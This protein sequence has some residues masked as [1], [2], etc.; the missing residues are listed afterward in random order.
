MTNNQTFLRQL[1][2]YVVTPIAL[3]LIFIASCF[4]LVQKSQTHFFEQQLFDFIE[5]SISKSHAQ[6]ND[7]RA[8]VIEQ[9]LELGPVQHLSLYNTQTA[10]IDHFGLPM[11]PPSSAQLHN[12]QPHWHSRNIAYKAFGLDSN[13]WLIAGISNHDLVIN[14]YKSIFFIVLVSIMVLG[15]VA[16]FTTRLHQSITDPLQ[17]IILQTRKLLTYEVKDLIS[18]KNPNIFQDL[19]N[20]INEIVKFQSAIHEEM[21]TFGE[22]STRELRETL[23]TVEIQNIELDIARKN[24]LQASKAKSEFLAN[25]SHELR[26]P[27][28]VILGFS[29]LLLKT[30]LSNQQRDYLATIEQSS[31]GLLTVINDIL[32]FS[33]LETGQL[34]LE[35]K[36][37]SLREI[38]EEI[39]AIYAPSAHEK[40]LRLLSMIHRNIPINLLGDPHRIK[41]V[42]TNLVT[43]A[44]KF[45]NRG[46]IVVRAASLSETDNRTEIKISI[47]DNGIGLTKEQQTQLFTAFSKVDSS[48][49]RLQGGA[50]LGL[51]IAKGLI[52]RM[53]GEIGVES[54][55]ATGSCFWFTLRLGVDKTKPG[56]S[57]LVNS[58]YGINALVYDANDD[59]RMEITQ[60]LTEWGVFYLEESN[61]VNIDQPLSESKHKAEIDLVILDAYTDLNSFDRDKLLRIVHSISARYQIPVIILAPSSIQ[62]L[63]HDDIIGLNTVIVQRPLQHALLHQ[64]ICNQL[65]IVQPLGTPESEPQET[66]SLSC[67]LRNTEVLVVEDNPANLKLVC[68]FLK[69]LGVQVSTAENGYSAIELCGER[70]FDLIF[71][72]VQMPGIDGLETTRQLR[73]N[74]GTLRTPI[75]ALTAHAIDEQKTRL[76]LA[77]MDDFLSKPVT[78][79][80]LRV[81]LNRW[82]GKVNAPQQGHDTHTCDTVSPDASSEQDSPK[83]FD[84]HESMERAR[85][86]PKLARDMLQMLADAIEPT[87]SNLTEA[88][89]QK[90]WQTM[91]EVAHKFY[92]GCC[93]CGVPAL[94]Q[95]TRRLEDAIKSADESTIKIQ[96]HRVFNDMDEFQAWLA[97]FDLDTL[98]EDE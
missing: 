44:I 57:A 37:I 36:P 6:G 50:G 92:G 98:F 3:A 28:N 71:M 47:T 35:Y 86:K 97:D 79:A 2:F 45:S 16:Y 11:K 89:A 78:E 72:D 10:R 43:N 66:S 7:H 40:N 34:T 74:E 80:D 23:E 49:S 69:G 15:F 46:H 48:D 61:L 75:I 90:N 60:R 52:N 82:S 63:M 77:G 22:Q 93:Y 54:N 19:V 25:T 27:L 65:D 33:K 70:N 94:R 81:M 9:L 17:S 58:L 67:G 1:L 41:Q 30:E 83:V 8:F 29:S 95:N 4:V 73:A 26:T 12:A 31:Q 55:T 85:H 96:A 24:A 21:R 64:A 32:D 59:S 38:I 62:R 88:L 51:A 84:W 14:E 87:R 56:V 68:E 5:Q 13:E 53:Q 39:L 76:L 18:V 91:D 20:I 42:I